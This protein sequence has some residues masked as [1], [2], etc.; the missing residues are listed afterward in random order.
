[1]SEI[2][3]RTQKQKLTL[4][5]ERG[6]II[7]AKSAG[8]NISAITEHLLRSITYDPH[9]NTIEDIVDAYQALFNAIWPLL[10]KYNATVEV[11]RDL[12]HNAILKISP[13]SH[14]SKSVLL[15]SIDGKRD[16]P[17]AFPVGKELVPYLYEP[18]VILQNLILAVSEGAQ[19]NQEKIRELNFALRFVKALS[20]D[21]NNQEIDGQNKK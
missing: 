1:M 13:T 14:V 9:G 12:G 21:S 16:R 3:N 7:R 10:D 19:K 11:G 20:E 15:K 5:I 4:G 2:Q 18:K 8:I 6:I 17:L